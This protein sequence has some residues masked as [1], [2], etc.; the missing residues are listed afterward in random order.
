MFLGGFIQGFLQQRRNQ[1]LLR[2]GQQTCPDSSAKMVISRN[3]HPNIK[4]NRDLRNKFSRSLLGYFL[5]SI[6]PI[7]AEKILRYIPE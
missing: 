5:L 3:I 1:M 4:Q 2:A 6:R 7:S